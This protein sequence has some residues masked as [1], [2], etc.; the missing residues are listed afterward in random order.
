MVFGR[1]K[2]EIGGG[3][4]RGATAANVNTK[5]TAAADAGAAYSSSHDNT[6]AGGGGNVDDTIIDD[7]YAEPSPVTDLLGIDTSAISL[8]GRSLVV[9]EHIG[10]GIGDGDHG[11][12]EQFDDCVSSIGTGKY[13]YGGPPGFT[14]KNGQQRQ[15]F[16]ASIG[17][18]GDL[19]II[20]YS[21]DYDHDYDYD[22][23][24]GVS[25]VVGL[26]AATEVTPMPSQIKKESYDQPTKAHRQNG[27]TSSFSSKRT[28]SQHHHDDDGASYTIGEDYS[29]RDVE[30]AAFADGHVEDQH[31]HGS[32]MHVEKPRPP[33]TKRSNTK[34]QPKGKKTSVSKQ[35]DVDHVDQNDDGG[36]RCLP[37]WLANA[38]FW[39]KIIIVSSLALLVG[40]VMLICLGAWF[41]SNDDGN[42]STSASTNDSNSN[43]SNDFTPITVPTMSPIPV[44]GTANEQQP[45]PSGP[46]STQ[47]Q[48]MASPPAG[49]TPAS[50]AGVDEIAGNNSSSNNN[51]PSPS[52]PSTTV[53]FYVIG[54]RFDGE[55]LEQLTV[56]LGLLPIATNTAATP[57]SGQDFPV[58]FHLGDWNSPFATSCDEASFQLNVETYSQS[59]VPVY[60]VP[61]DNEFNGTFW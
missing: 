39:L 1:R 56:D 54:G 43:N 38:P 2:G 36:T 48:P 16:G 28:N 8:D 59:T 15:H 26:A 11:D 17:Y 42:S 34:Q 4:A 10:G 51:N 49:V 44:D 40:A 53:S 46:T 12:D 9:P 3:V 33:T 22:D 21:N 27:T 35:V 45:Q 30:S 55:G 18:I 57:G 50:P 23:D 24:D 41:A 13:T 37:A 61:G 60:F 19:R 14:T 5:S 58:L 31:G 20:G 32:D 7:A 25:D 6:R 52:V 47:S 29:V